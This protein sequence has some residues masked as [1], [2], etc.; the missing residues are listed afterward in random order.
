MY[1]FSHVLLF[2][3]VKPRIDRTNLKPIVVRAGKPVK[4]DVDVR[5]E[6]PPETTWYHK[7]TLVKSIGNI[8]IVDVEYNTKIS[9]TDTT[10]ANTGLWKIKAVNAHGEDEA[11][12]EITV[13]CEYNYNSQITS[14]QE[15]CCN[16]CS[17]CIFSCTE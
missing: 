15:S 1:V 5:G 12:V 4:Y 14:L 2:I 7:D 17:L 11:E 6:P 16:Y 13:L 8:E 9:I 10:R 3:I